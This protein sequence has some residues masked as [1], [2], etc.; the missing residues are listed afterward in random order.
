M[1]PGECKHIIADYLKCLK[2][3]RGVNDEDCRKL[4]KSYLG[5][6]MDR[7]LMAP[8]DFKNLGLAFEEDKNGSRGKDGSSSGSNRAA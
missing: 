3:R 5:C 2:S 6:R 7:N 1:S 8:D 4:A